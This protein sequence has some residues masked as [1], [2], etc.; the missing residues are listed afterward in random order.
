[1]LKRPYELSPQQS[2]QLLYNRFVNTSGCVGNNISADLHMEHMNR[3]IKSGLANMSCATLK[4]AII[5]LGKAIGT[6]SPVLNNFDISTEIKSHRS[7]N[8][9]KKFDKISNLL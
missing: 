4:A 6:L 3:E 2:E 5:R 7:G 9:P 8:K 1:M